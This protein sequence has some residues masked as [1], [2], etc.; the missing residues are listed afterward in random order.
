MYI[1]IVAVIG[2]IVTVETAASLLLDKEF[3]D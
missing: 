2:G 1:A 3:D